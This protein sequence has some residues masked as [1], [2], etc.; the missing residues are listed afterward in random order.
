[1]KNET[2][3]LI[4]MLTEN[5]LTVDNAE[6]VFSQCSDSEVEYWGMK[7]KPLPKETMK[8]LFSE[9]KKAGKTTFLEVVGYTEDEGLKGAELAKE[10][11]CD[12]LM[13]TKFHKSISDYCAKSGIKY[14]PFVGTIIGRPSVLKGTITD[15]IEEAKKAINNGAY[16]ID[17]LAYRY[18]EDPM[19]LS[20]ALINEIDAP[21]CM[22]GSVDSFQ[23]LEEVKELNPW[24]FTIGSAFF[25]N[26]FGETFRGQVELVNEY[27]N[28]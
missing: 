16:G 18:T 10:C 11:G 20:Q 4:V 15:I 26:K 14:M 24:A 28:S 9:M 23:R 5:D 19:E 7:E 21:V 3:K 27:M 8:H 17:L 12:I 22:A 13:G 1:M 25:N 6:E 2:P